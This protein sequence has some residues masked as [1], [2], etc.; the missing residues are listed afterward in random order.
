MLR[1]ASFPECSM[2]RCTATSY[3]QETCQRVMPSTNFV[4]MSRL[5][6]VLLSTVTAIAH[7]YNIR[8]KQK[9][10]Q[11]TEDS[12]H[13]DQPPSARTKSEPHRIPGSLYLFQQAIQENE[14]T[15][16]RP[17]LVTVRFRVLP[18]GSFSFGAVF[19]EMD[20]NQP[21]R[22]VQNVVAQNQP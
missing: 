19:G 2:Q 16:H 7:M 18:D 6:G 12:E 15:Q 3:G 4:V 17:Q 14:E 13:Q 1:C 9:L 5:D 20:P 10:A 8:P 22:H 21:D 11:H